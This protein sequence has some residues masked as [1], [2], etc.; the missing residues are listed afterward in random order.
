MSVQNT[1]QV[2]DTQLP[3]P[4]DQQMKDTASTVITP[5]T[6]SANIEGLAKAV[7]EAPADMNIPKAASH[8]AD[9]ATVDAL[10]A[11]LAKAVT[12][13]ETAEKDR[14]A[15]EENNRDLQNA[16]VTQANTI[17]TLRDELTASVQPAVPGTP[18]STPA[19]HLDSD[20]KPIPGTRQWANQVI[21]DW[22]NVHFHVSKLNAIER[23]E[24][25]EHEQKRV[26]A[27]VSE[28]K[29]LLGV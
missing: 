6:G 19:P 15:L 23:G 22:F 20:G 29:G 1:E 3:A 28:L 27:A 7:G 26:S 11:D 18:P 2:T 4:A 21:E 8:A 5:G 9:G 10:R 17:S 12:A 25:R 24:W 14:Q 16:L 13:Y